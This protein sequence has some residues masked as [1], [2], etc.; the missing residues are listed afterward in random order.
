MCV[1]NNPLLIL[2]TVISTTVNSNVVSYV[3]TV[4][5]AIIMSSFC[6]VSVNGCESIIVPLNICLDHNVLAAL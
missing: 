5:Y 4:T 2:V 3:K 1:S 6:V